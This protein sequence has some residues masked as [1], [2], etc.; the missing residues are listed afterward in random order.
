MAKKKPTLADIRANKGKYQYSKLHIDTWDE[1]AACEAAGI[2]MLSVATEFITDPRFRQMTPSTFAV[3]GRSL[4]DNE[5][6][7]DGFLRWGYQAMRH[8]AD[9]VYCPTSFGNI[10]KLADEAI[11]VIGHVGLIPSKASWT[12][13]FKAVGKTAE[14]AMQVWDLVRRYEDAG[15]FGVEIEVVPPDIAAEISKR[16]SLFM[17]SMGSGTGCDAQYLFTCDVLGETRGHIP[18][19][20][21]VYRNFAKEMDRLQNERIAAFKEFHGDVQTSAFP[22]ATQVTQAQPGQFE[23]FLKLLEKTKHA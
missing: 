15:A 2:D 23:K 16:T 7:P 4:Y 19:H 13:G 12:G 3:V 17:I 9:A 20:A 21:K 22:E 10:R 5:G 18:K 6:T 14:S 8:G 1:I 11:P